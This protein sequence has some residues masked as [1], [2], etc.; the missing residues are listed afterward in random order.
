MV[1]YK[2]IGLQGKRLQISPGEEFIAAL[3]TW[4][5]RAGAMDLFSGVLIP[6]A[7]T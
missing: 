6:E 1:G 4:Q 2:I 3:K 7:V 5:S